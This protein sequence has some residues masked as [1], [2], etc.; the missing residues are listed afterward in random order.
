MSGPNADG[1][2]VELSEELA[3]YYRRMLAKHTGSPC[4]VCGT[5]RCPDFVFAWTQLVRAGRL[6][7]LAE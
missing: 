7:D 3:A 6:I 4:P 2:P 1:E 5:S